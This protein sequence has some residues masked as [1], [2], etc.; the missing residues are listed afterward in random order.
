MA[1]KKLPKP[2][3]DI[4]ADEVGETVQSFISDDGVKQM[5]VLQQ[6]DGT[7]TVTPED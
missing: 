7:F 2:I 5:E 1:T 3:K 4:P 6:K